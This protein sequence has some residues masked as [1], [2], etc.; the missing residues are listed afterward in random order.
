MLDR[1]E[2]DIA[3][4]ADRDASCGAARGNTLRRDRRCAQGEIVHR[5]SGTLTIGPAEG[6]GIFVI[7]KQEGAP[8]IDLYLVLR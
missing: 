2:G 6:A 3:R 7:G 4:A 5:Q 1:A 8:A